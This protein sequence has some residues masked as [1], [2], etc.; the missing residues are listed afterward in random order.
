MK[1]HF[2]KL[3]AQDF[4][5]FSNLFVIRRNIIRETDVYEDA[6]F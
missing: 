2:F 6:Y 3:K 4:S 5:L 1:I